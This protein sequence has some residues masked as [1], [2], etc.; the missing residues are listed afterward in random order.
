MLLLQ[1]QQQ[2]IHHHHNI[3][4]SSSSNI[5]A[6]THGS[7]QTSAQQQSNFG[8]SSSGSSATFA[9]VLSSSYGISLT[10]Y[11]D[12][13]DLNPGSSHHGLI[14]SLGGN[15]GSAN[16]A[17]GHHP[18]QQVAPAAQH[19]H[20]PG[21]HPQQ[22]QHHHHHG[23]S[24]YESYDSIPNTFHGEFITQPI[25]YQ[26]ARGRSSPPTG[27]LVPPPS[28][29]SNAGSPVTHSPGP[30]IVPSSPSHLLPSFL[31]TYN[32]QQY[33]QQ[34]QQALQQQQAQQQHQQVVG[35]PQ[36]TTLEPRYPFKTELPE[37][38]PI[39][40]TFPPPPPSCSSPSSTPTTSSSAF[41]SPPYQT[42]G[43]SNFLLKKEPIYTCTTAFVPNIAP[44]SPYQSNSSTNYYHSPSSPSY[45]SSSS[46]NN[47]ASG[48]SNNPPTNNFDRPIVARKTSAPR[49]STSTSQGS[50]DAVSKLSIRVP[51][52]PPPPS[53][54][55]ECSPNK[56]SLLCAVCG[57]NAAC[58]HYGVRTC[59]G[60]K[61]FFKRTVQKNAKYVCL[62][63]K[64]CPV[65]KRR[66]N[67]CQFC[68]F[69]KCLAVGMVKE[70]VRTDSLKGRRGRLPS[71]PKSPTESPPSPPVS[72][73]T[74]LVRAHIDTSPD[75]NNL[76]YSQFVETSIE[77]ERDSKENM[78]A[79]EAI[80]IGQFYHVLT[81]SIEVIRNFC[82]RIPGISELSLNDRDLL[83]QTSCLELF[84]LRLAY[85]SNPDSDRYTFC[86]GV[87]LHVSQCEQTFGDWLNGINEFARGLHSMELDISAFS[88]L[89]GLILVNGKDERHG[90]SDPKKVESIENKII[91]SLKDHVTYNPEA[92][93]K[94]HYMTR[95]LDRLPALRSLSMQGLQ[96]I[97]FLKWEDLV[98]APPLIEKM[99]AS[100][101]P[102]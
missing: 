71:K 29:S 58:Q 45:F 6:S 84:V 86:N 82:E 42:G 81:S 49:A 64:N 18:Q 92:Q 24:S 70:V 25:D 48:S 98:P 15:Y 20:H 51:L 1:H 31:D 61:G 59:E 19:H 26:G 79:N 102:F 11:G 57:D 13:G 101:I 35:V 39:C 32:R 65:D 91:N 100:S 66:R 95:I 3:H 62:A 80:K 4:H 78:L 8:S 44:N 41:T 34:Q 38:K 23:E 63:D 40:S 77:D 52:G 2:S 5:N 30:I 12:E 28:S 96:R 36:P 21:H 47:T 33:E 16:P 56:A 87:V 14:E 85:R 94:E 74:A 83:F 53:L 10:D 43:G 54:S 88:C 55:S 73:I 37:A 72:L 90:L 99:F 7:Q 17:L 89:C 68:R 76:D 67:R 97:F 69:Q 60:C 75:M 22:Q 27:P 46:A 9:D 93:K 50:G